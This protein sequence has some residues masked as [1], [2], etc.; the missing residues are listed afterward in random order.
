MESQPPITTALLAQSSRT[1]LDRI[2]ASF[3][4][5]RIDYE[6][7][8]EGSIKPSKRVTCC[9]YAHCDQRFLSERSRVRAE[10][11]VFLFQQRMTYRNRFN[12][13]SVEADCAQAVILQ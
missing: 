4:D 1:L 9:R 13:E 6:S 3:Q 7:G 5:G 2:G 11:G 8:I 12:F 10:N